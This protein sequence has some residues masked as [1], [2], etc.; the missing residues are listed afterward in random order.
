MGP[1]GIPSG[2]IGLAG[3]FPHQAVRLSCSL[4]W[5]HVESE[6]HEQA[7]DS[8]QDFSSSIFSQTLY[9]FSPDCSKHA[10]PAGSSSSTL[11]FSSA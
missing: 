2:W 7:R 6:I 4:G 10:N 8:V 9:I 3:G 5:G 1:C 11:R